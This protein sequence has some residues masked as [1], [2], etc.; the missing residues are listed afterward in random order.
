MAF[1]VIRNIQDEIDARRQVFESCSL[2]KGWGDFFAGEEF[3]NIP[4]TIVEEFDTEG[5]EVVGAP[6]PVVHQ[7][8]RWC[9]KGN[10]CKLA[11]CRNRH[12]RCEHYDKWVASRGKTRGCRCQQ[13]D[14][15][16]C[17][18]PE[19][20][21]CKYDHRD[22][23]KLVTYIDKLDVDTEQKLWD[24]FY[25]RGMDA[26]GPSQYSTEQMENHNRKL[27]I[28]SLEASGVKYDDGGSYL[29]IWFY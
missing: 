10:A 9:R 16:N 28:R 17:K 26:V 8:P 18:S 4:S 20:G 1:N 24:N 13:T 22:P 14:P 25:E 19:D 23:K 12:E 15:N 11:N 27:L 6:A 5:W 21:G 29:A 3:F 7:A 2:P